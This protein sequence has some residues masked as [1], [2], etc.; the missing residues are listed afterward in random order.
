MHTSQRL[1]VYDVHA[2]DMSCFLLP[3]SYIG[4]T[5]ALHCEQG[6]ACFA[7]L[8]AVRDRGQQHQATLLRDSLHFVT[9][10]HGR[11]EPSGTTR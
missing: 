2:T 3:I 8:P 10:T 6:F 1:I 5:I 7:E 9:A 4:S 11:G